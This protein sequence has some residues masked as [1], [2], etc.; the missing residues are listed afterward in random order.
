[1]S[2]LKKSEMIHLNILQLLSEENHLSASK[3]INPI[4]PYQ[5][6]GHYDAINT[7][8]AGNRSQL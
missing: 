8:R 3:P 7:I 5:T 2:A 6:G 4:D 1:M